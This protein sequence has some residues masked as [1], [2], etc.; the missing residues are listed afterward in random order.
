VGQV[1]AAQGQAPAAG[2][3]RPTRPMSA[4]ERDHLLKL[5]HEEADKMFGADGLPKEKKEKVEKA[6]QMAIS[7]GLVDEEEIKKK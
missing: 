1:T 2:I 5:L 6:V 4:A 7:S 3:R